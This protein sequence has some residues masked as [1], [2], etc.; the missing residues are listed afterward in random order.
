MPRPASDQHFTDA[1]FDSRTGIYTLA[2]KHS[3]VARYYANTLRMNV[4]DC[5]PIVEKGYREDQKKVPQTVLVVGEDSWVNRVA[6]HYTTWTEMA[7]FHFY[8]SNVN[9]GT[10]PPWLPIN[11]AAAVFHE[12]RPGIGIFMDYLEP[13]YIYKYFNDSAP[14]PTYTAPPSAGPPLEVPPPPPSL[15]YSELEVTGKVGDKDINLLLKFK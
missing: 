11:K 4:Q 15:A 5:K 10:I 6:P 14:P 8:D 7:V 3:Y 1:Q 12:Y 13:T 2:N 9:P